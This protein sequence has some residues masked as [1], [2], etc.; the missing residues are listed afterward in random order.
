[1]P[2]TVKC[3]VKDCDWKGQRLQSH[4][5]RSHPDTWTKPRSRSDQARISRDKKDKAEEMERIRKDQAAGA[6]GTTVFRPAGYNDMVKHLE[7]L[8]DS[9]RERLAKIETTLEDLKD[10]VTDEAQPA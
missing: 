2:K 8:A 7:G 5:T 9:Y 4:V 6:T 10:L 1:M 3:T